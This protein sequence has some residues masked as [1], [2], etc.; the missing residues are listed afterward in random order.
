[1]RS[2]EHRRVAKVVVTHWRASYCRL[3]RKN[4]FP[5]GARTGTR[6]FVPSLEMLVN[7]HPARSA[8]RDTTGVQLVPLRSG[9]CSNVHG[10]EG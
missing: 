7:G 9:L 10:V 5:A 2:V 1:M 4:R 8:P 3:K 6:L